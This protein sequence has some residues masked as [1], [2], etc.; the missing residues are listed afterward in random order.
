MDQA[1][2]A[3]VGN[4][5]KFPFSETRRQPRPHRV[6]VVQERGGLLRLLHRDRHKVRTISRTVREIEII[7][8]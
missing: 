4:K 8:F 2:Y 6:E 5:I 1:F 3:H 7:I